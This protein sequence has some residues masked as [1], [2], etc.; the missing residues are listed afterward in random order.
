ML[1]WGDGSYG[2]NA[3]PV[4]KDLKGVNIK[5]VVP[6]HFSFGA[7][8]ENGGVVAW[9]NSRNGGRPDEATKAKI[10]D[11]VKALAATNFAFAALKNDGSVVAW[12]EP[13]GGGKVGAILINIASPRLP[14]GS[15]G[16]SGFAFL[17]VGR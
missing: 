14:A 12:G 15:P 16:C 9:G 2:G 3:R 11:G 13:H 10:H 6:T 1:V 8:T 5:H 7:L 4:E 17:V